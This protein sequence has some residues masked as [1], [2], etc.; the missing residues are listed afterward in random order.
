M[1]HNIVL[2]G[3]SVFDNSAYVPGQSC[4]TEQLRAIM[5]P[6]NEVLMLAVD[7][8]FVIDVRGQLRRVPERATHLFVSAGGNDALSQYEMLFAECADSQELFEE[9]SRIQAGFRRDY[10]NMLEAVVSLNRHTAVCTVYD[11]VPG[12]APFAITALSLFNDVIVAEAVA[13]GVSIIDLRRVC[14]EAQDFSSI[15]PIE[16]SWQG[17]A[18]I[19][20]VLKR[21]AEGHGPGGGRCV[22]YT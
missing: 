2:L 3:D 18:K 20:A 8:H 19:A 1:S 6:D 14:T 15:S 11:A 17:G 22:V 4:L 16:P 13:A 21:V 5:G 7:G 12:V 10:R 9:W